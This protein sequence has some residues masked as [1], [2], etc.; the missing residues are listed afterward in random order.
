MAQN[1]IVK[2]RVQDTAAFE[3]EKNRFFSICRSG[4]IF[5]FMESV[6]FLSNVGHLV[7]EYDHY[8]SLCTHIVARF[9]LNNAVMKIEL[10]LN[11]GADVSARESLTGD[12]LLHIA[13]SSKNYELAE[14]LCRDLKANLIAINYAHLT[15]Y[16]LAY[17]FRDQRMMEI[18][19]SNGAVYDD[20]VTSGGSGGF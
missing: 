6:P 4:N 20:P 7:H 5:E 1:N 12:S 10:L 16:H 9:D 15:P 14:W 11:M 13:V 17:F 18:L 2:N 19:K 8:G 3:E